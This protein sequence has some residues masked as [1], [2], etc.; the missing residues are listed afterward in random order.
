MGVPG[1]DTIAWP[2][3]VCKECG[4]KSA[5]VAM[6]CPECG[7]SWKKVSPLA[8]PES[9]AEH[10]RNALQL[11]DVAATPASTDHFATLLWAVEQSDARDAARARLR[12]ALEML[13]RG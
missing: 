12:Q 13:E 11:L 5:T 6:P 3:Y 4:F 1:T 7:G 10:I 8:G 2:Q 9:A